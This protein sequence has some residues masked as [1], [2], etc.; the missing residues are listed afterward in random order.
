[1]E[2]TAE[3]TGD[4]IEL[5]V[6]GVL[7]SNWADPLENAIGEAV[8]GGSHR[9][10]L[11]LQNVTY[12][13]SAGISVLLR[14]H[15]QLQQIHG[16]FGVCDPSPQ[17][18]QVLRLTGL[19]QRLICDGETVRRSKGTM[20]V[21]ARPDYRCVALGEVEF[22]LYDQSPETPLKCRTFGNAGR[23][24]DRSFSAGQSRRVP[25]GRET[26]GLGLGAF[27]NG[28]DECRERF[29]EFLA[30]GGTAVQ[31]PGQAGSTPDYQLAR[32]NFIPVI[33]VLYGLQ[34][35][36]DFSQL[37][38]FENAKDSAPIGFSTLVEQCLSLAEADLTGMVFVAESAGLVG[39][40]LKRSPAQQSVGA[41]TSADTFTHP[42]IREWL[43]FSPEHVHL[44]SLALVVGVAGRSPL[45]NGSASLSPLLRPLNAAGTI[46]GHFHAAVF[47]YRP[48]KKRRLDLNQ[49]LASLFE[50]EHLHGLLHL[51]SDFRE[52]SGAGES[53]FVSGACWFGPI[54]GVSGEGE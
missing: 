41:G 17:V 30:A 19:E 28:F 34:C 3:R 54:A 38:R 4:L 16:F 36:G 50:S 43:S 12:L 14:A 35:T 49:T 11:N 45:R 18:R 51:L 25:F 26:F 6:R 53:E 7:D 39:A 27:G 1:M 48:L 37:A 46:S 24:A 21:T 52:I 33:E 42:E 15:S 40:A 8:R 31:L 23:L 9:M 44:R 20:L 22:E 13:S 2:I 47:S 32:E 29:G 10:L 5:H